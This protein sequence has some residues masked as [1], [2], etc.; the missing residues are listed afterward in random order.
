MPLDGPW[1]LAPLAAAGPPLPPAPTAWSLPPRSPRFPRPQPEQP[2][3]ARWLP[4]TGLG[5]LGSHRVGT[6]ADS[7]G[8]GTLQSSGNDTLISN[9]KP[10]VGT[11]SDLLLIGA[12]GQPCC[13]E[14]PE[15]PWLA[16]TQ[17][18]QGRQNEGQNQVFIWEF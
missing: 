12:V 18:G 6:V 8:R 13:R 16:G 4:A 2:C 5:G 11:G 3:R 1:A 9:H 17:V 14:G 15:T 7:D 10:H